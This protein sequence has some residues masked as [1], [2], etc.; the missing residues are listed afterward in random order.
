M[1][2]GSC[3]KVGY[4]AK[5]HGLKGEVT[6]VVTESL[7]LQKSTSVLVEVR[8]ALVPYFIQ[9]ISDRGD[10][11][12]VKLED[13]DSPEQAKALKGCGLYLPKNVRPRLDRGEFYD[14]EVIGFEVEDEKLGL[15]GEIREVVQIGPNRLLAIDRSAKELLIPIQ[16]PFIQ[17][18][19][20][21]KKKV[22]VDL[23]EGFLDI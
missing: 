2:I 19:N 15:L 6:I 5:T 8:G 1:D 20:K 11:A 18:V 4:I 12:F 7:P 22:R 16:G 23:P 21:S 17:S 3:Y 13:V 10:K 9:H 14:D